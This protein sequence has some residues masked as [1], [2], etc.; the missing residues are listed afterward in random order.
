[1]SQ[2]PK[3]AIILVYLQFERVPLSSHE[4][5]MEVALIVER[6]VDEEILDFVEVA[7]DIAV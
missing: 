3:E 7:P 4:R 2:E 5:D 6:N 1:M